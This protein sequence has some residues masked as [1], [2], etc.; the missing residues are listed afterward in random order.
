MSGKAGPQIGAA[1]PDTGAGT[2]VRG[3]GSR[4]PSENMNVKNRGR[5]RAKPVVLGPMLMLSR[6]AAAGQEPDAAGKGIT[7]VEATVRPGREAGT[8]PRAGA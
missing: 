3:G 8:G 7:Q 6:G 5:A 1:V 2:A 4:V